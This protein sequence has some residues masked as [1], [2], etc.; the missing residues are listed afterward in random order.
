[1]T[2]DG[3]GAAD[4]GAA[5][6]DDPGADDDGV[7]DVTSDGPGDQ[8]A[9]DPADSAEP[10]TDDLLADTPN[11]EYLGTLALNH[12][13]VADEPFLV[14]VADESQ[15]RMR[16]LMFVIEEEM[17]PLPDGRRRGML[18][19]WPADNSTGF[20]MRDTIIPLDVAFIREDGSIDSIHTMTPLDE[21][22]YPPNG[23]YRYALEVNAGTFAEL[24]VA[25][26]DMVELPQRPV[27][28]WRGTRF[29]A[30]R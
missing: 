27:S 9:D 29:L 4:T 16:G 2:D 26:E 23:P 21:S 24:G 5:G 6:Q 8:A 25:A 1:M 12:V 13:R 22:T 11:A 7:A 17:A 28:G 19:V 20:W 14:W 30:A 3:T 18:F 15:T 10:P